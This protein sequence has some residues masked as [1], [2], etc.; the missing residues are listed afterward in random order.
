MIKG[1][2]LDVDGVLVGGKQGYNWPQPN[3]LVITALKNL[4][5]KGIIVSLCTG[6]GTFAIKEIVKA[7]HL[8]NI[9]IGDGG[10]VVVDFLNNKIITKHVIEK[11]LAIKIIE[12]LQKNN[13]YIE[14]YTINNYYIEKEKINEN[15]KK[16]HAAILYRQPVITESFKKLVKDFNVIKIMPIPKDNLQKQ[17]V[18]NIYDSFKDLLSLQWGVH[19]TALPAHFGIITQKGISKR[20]AAI[21]ISKTTNIPLKKFL[22]VGDGLSDWNFMEICGYAGAIGNASQELKDLVRTKNKFGFI[23]PN[24]DENGIL[25]IFRH[26]NLIS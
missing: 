2:I 20:Q 13:I 11:N 18:I 6:K 9:H 26:F 3:P 10:A 17:Q 22:G 5:Q 23:G 25:E 4:R 24:V 1:I 8:N 15:L 16:I 12:A 19:P 21:T 14:V 7:A